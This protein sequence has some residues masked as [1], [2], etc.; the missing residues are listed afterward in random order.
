MI[1]TSGWHLKEMALT[2]FPS[3]YLL[4]SHGSRDP[5]P[6]VEM[7]RLAEMVAQQLSQNDLMKAGGQL[8]TASIV[9]AAVLELA[10]P[11]H[12]QIQQFAERAVTLGCQHL[13]IVPIFLLPGVHVVEDIPAEVAIA[14]QKLE[15]KIALEICPYLGSH[16]HLQEFWLDF[17]SG[18]GIPEQGRVLLGH[19][20]RRVG[21][22]Q[23]MEAIAAQLGA[24][25]AYWSVAPSLPDQI[26]LLVGQ[27]CTQ[28]DILPYFLF[29]GGITDAIAQSVQELAQQ[30]PNVDL[31]WTPPRGAT[32]KL[33]SFV[34]EAIA[35]SNE[36]FNT[37]RE[38]ART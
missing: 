22:N 37:V 6:Q 36:A 7:A 21:G 27:S 38:S 32:V 26:H 13:Y 12:Q 28:I 1:H 16:P 14:E 4:V 31:R 34:V 5:R 19:G 11:L 35:K 29:E 3:A 8:P 33:A 10:S 25:P 20:S 17:A 2:H 9:E 30:L 24:L 18:F 23:A 15:G